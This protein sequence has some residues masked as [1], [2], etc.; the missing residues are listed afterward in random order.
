MRLRMICLSCLLTAVTLLSAQSIRRHECWID[1]DYGNR[2]T[3]SEVD[4][5]SL[6]F[7]TEGLAPGLHFLN[8]RAQNTD[9]EWGFF[10]RT[11]FFIPLDPLGDSPLG[12]YEYWVDA[13]YENRVVANG[14]HADLAASIDI[15]GLAAG[16]HF[17]NFRGLNDR[18][19]YGFLS[20]TMFFIPESTDG[21]PVF[22]ECEYRIDDAEPTVQ[23]GENLLGEY[24]LTLDVTGLAEGDHV[25]SFRAKN[26]NG[27]WGELFTETFTI[28]DKDESGID[29]AMA[30]DQGVDVYSLKGALVQR[31]VKNL[32]RLPRGIYV[33]DGRKVMVR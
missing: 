14:D 32:K 30:D 13:D 5:I 4:S 18:G 25:F 31:G 11:M 12:G 10:Y 21:Q 28:L 27:L 33:V 7:S 2:Q 23:A 22:V 24:L 6:A 8:H 17:F 16:L 26:G 20:R 9:G 1:A 19:E 15:S 29:G 3:V